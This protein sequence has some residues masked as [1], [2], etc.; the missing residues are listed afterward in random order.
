MA[1]RLVDD[2]RP[3]SVGGEEEYKVRTAS[4]ITLEQFAPFAVQRGSAT[5]S[6]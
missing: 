2:E 1:T 3:Q 5:R 4:G 6:S